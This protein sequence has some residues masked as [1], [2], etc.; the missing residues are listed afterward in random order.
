MLTV[1]RQ[2][3]YAARILLHLAMQPP[4]THLMAR[5]IARLRLMPPALTRRV[6]AQLV[7]AGFLQ[8][9]RGKGGGFALARSPAEISL[10]EVVEAM[11]GPIALN[12]CTLDPQECP[13]M[14]QCSVHEAWVDARRLLRDYLNLLTFRELARRGQTLL[15]SS[16]GS[17]PTPGSGRS[18]P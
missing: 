13:L 4:G 5:E 10:L 3:D 1:R 18:S 17:P 11:D 9:R 6:V 15:A 7:A 16:P 12:R 2:C 14:P 8:S